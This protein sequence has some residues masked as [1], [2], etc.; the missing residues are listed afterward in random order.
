L[1]DMAFINGDRRP[2]SIR[3]KTRVPE[4][5]LRCIIEKNSELA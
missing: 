5:E 3:C 4:T 1:D 2:C